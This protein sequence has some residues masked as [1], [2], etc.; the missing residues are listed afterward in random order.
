MTE[1]NLKGQVIWVAGHNGMVGS[2]ICRQLENN[3]CKIV[4]VDR[5]E[6]DLRNATEV[7]AWMN[8]MKPD[9]VFLA[10]ATVGGILANNTRPAE[11]IRDNLAIELNVIH[12][13]WQTNV[14]KLLL[15]GSSCIYPKLSAQPITEDSLLTGPLE[16]TNQWYA[17]A[18]IAGIKLCQAYRLQYGVNFISAMPTNLYGPGDNFDLESGHVMPSLMRKI[19][20]AKLTNAEKVT[21]WGSGKPCREFLYV[22]DCADALIHIMQLYSGENPLNV[23]C[24]K[25][26]SILALAAQIADVVGYEGDFVFDTTKPDGTPRKL[27]DISR[28]KKLG[29]KPSTDFNHGLKLTYEWYKANNR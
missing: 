7:E 22:D 20:E 12:S 1:F 19:H 28:L 13:A 8:D 15:L 14:K 27:L 23:G 29:W 6:V 9:V 24:G 16:P 17:V 25:D 4:T 10:A 3:D 21:I 2:A 18:K 5:S 11:F 26:I